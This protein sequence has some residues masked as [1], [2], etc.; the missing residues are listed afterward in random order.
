MTRLLLIWRTA[1]GPRWRSWSCGLSIAASFALFGLAA[2]I[3]WGL[4]HSTRPTSD[5]RLVV[6]NALAMSQSLPM[7]YLEQISAIDG[8]A[9]VAPRQ[10]FGGWFRTPHNS[11]V[12]YVVNPVRDLNVH[13]EYRMPEQARVAFLAGGRAVLVGKALAGRFNWNEGDIVTLTTE[14]WPQP[15]GSDRWT[16]TIAGV[17][18]VDSRVGAA[19]PDT[20]VMLIDHAFFSQLLPYARHLAGWFVVKLKKDAD[21]DLVS[22]LID[23]QFAVTSAPTQTSTERL[24][25]MRLAR[26]LGDASAI[27]IFVAGAIAIVLF[28]T[29][30]LF[31]FQNTAND[32]ARLRLLHALGFTRGRICVYLAA[33]AQAQCLLFALAGLAIAAFLV[34][35]IASVFSSVVP[36]IFLPAE[37]IVVGLAVAATLGTAGAAFGVLNLRAVTS[38]T[39]T[40]GSE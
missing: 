35:I 19:T 12:Q 6:V 30:S 13:P 15:D 17:F 26:Q 18:G 40:E 29:T 37:R 2:A 7:D 4:S 14:M 32:K 9:G 33:G 23:R 34:P 1:N 38:S 20:H 11:F 36:G 10:W 25:S 39:T 24:F 3:D 21:P 27:A 22:R 28:F 5:D 16:F 8:V 31:F